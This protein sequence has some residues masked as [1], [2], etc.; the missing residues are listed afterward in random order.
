MPEPLNRAQRRHPDKVD[1]PKRPPDRPQSNQRD[2][3]KDG[4]QDDVSTR[5]KSSGHKKKTADKWNQ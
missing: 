3:A 4:P 2:I 5:A 1:D